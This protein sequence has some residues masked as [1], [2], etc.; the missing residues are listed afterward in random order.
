[1]KILTK[2][3]CCSQDKGQMCFKCY[4]LITFDGQNNDV[5]NTCVFYCLYL[6]EDPIIG[7]LMKLH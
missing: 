4:E 5:F 3:V 6:A 7:C 2:S 1:M